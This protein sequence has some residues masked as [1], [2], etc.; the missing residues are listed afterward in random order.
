MKNGEGGGQQGENTCILISD[1]ENFSS[2]PT[3]LFPFLSK[4][5]LLIKVRGPIFILKL[6]SL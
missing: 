4:N 2:F 3:S 5:P 6:S 1:C